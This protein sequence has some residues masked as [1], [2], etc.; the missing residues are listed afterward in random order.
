MF[1]G[2]KLNNFGKHIDA[3]VTFAPGMNVLRGANEVGKS[4][5]IDSILYL[6]FGVRALSRSLADMVTYGQPEKSLRVD[7]CFEIEGVEYTAYRHPGGAEITYGNQR[8]TGQS[9]VTQFMETIL[10][11]KADVV[12]K[13][14]IAEQNS[15]RGILESEAQA[16]E[17]IESLAELSVIDDL[18]DKIKNQLPCGPTKGQELTI[19]KLEA[20]IP[21]I[22]EEPKTNPEIAV[23]EAQHVELQSK[24]AEASLKVEKTKADAINANAR[25]LEIQQLQR[26]R[27]SWLSKREALLAVPDV[28]T[29]P[30]TDADYEEACRIEELAKN[31]QKAELARKWAPK[32]HAASWEGSE[33]SLDDEI[34]KTEDRIQRNNQ[35]LADLRVKYATVKSTTI[36]EGVCSFCKKDLSELPEVQVVN[37]EVQ[38]KLTALQAEASALKESLDSDSEDLKVLKELKAVQLANARSCEYTFWAKI[39][40][41]VPSAYKWIGPE[42]VDSQAA[43]LPPSAI[44]KAMLDWAKAD[45]R[46][47]TAQ[48]DLASLIEPVVPDESASLSAKEVLEAYK[49]SEQELAGLSLEGVKLNKELDSLKYNDSVATMTYKNSVATRDKYLQ[50]LQIHKDIL[51]AMEFNNQLVKDLREA[52]S[53]LRREIWSSCS[54]VIST[55]FSRIRK[56]DTRIVQTEKGFTANG[57]PVSGLSGSAKDMLGLA[58]RA[59]LIKTFIPNAPLLVV[60]E[61]FAGCDSERESAGIAVLSSLQFPQTLLITHSDLADSMA[62]KLV[63]LG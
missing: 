32:T 53:Q 46:Y 59:G 8:V 21:E 29:C 51:T 22:G 27:A 5:L 10:G 33:Q 23:V 39:E 28:G 17:L 14:M 30:Y 4:T 1:K 45:D 48:Q 44:Q 52:R 6:W 36:N 58:I 16:G 18:I 50:D 38:K 3:Y 37:A 49:L 13:L 47:R 62:D 12:R 54:A 57:K 24:V 26:E 56:V 15:I 31:I 60:D 55:Y 40:G 35:A 34:V 25:L 11:A 9:N 20:S 2:I 7:G 42:K 43:Y 61:P 41:T 63:Q 19:Q